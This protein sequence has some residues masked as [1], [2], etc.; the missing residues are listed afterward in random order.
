M[1]Q[2]ENT[3]LYTQ[4]GTMNIFMLNVNVKQ[5]RK[6]EEESHSKVKQKK[7]KS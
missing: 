6:R 4:S 5:A 3:I 1:K 7:W 2:W